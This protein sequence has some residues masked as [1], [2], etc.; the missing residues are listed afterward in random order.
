[1]ASQKFRLWIIP[2]V[3]HKQQS[4]LRQSI[5]ESGA[6]ILL[7]FCVLAGGHQHTPQLYRA[8]AIRRQVLA[9]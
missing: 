3:S 1:M 5:Q 9:E 7:E 6:S 2:I 4:P 8:T